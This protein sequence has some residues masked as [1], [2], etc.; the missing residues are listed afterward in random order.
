[1]TALNG[2]PNATTVGV[3]LFNTSAVGMIQGQA[4]A[5]PATR[6]ALRGGIVSNNETVP[7]W[8]GIGVYANVPPI[9][10]NGPR[11]PLGPV[12][13]RA[14][15]LSTLVG[16][17]TFD[18]SYNMI[19]NPAS[20]VPTAGSGQSLNFY[21]LGSRARLAV[22][23]DPA[24]VSLRGGA[25][26]PNVSWDYVNNLLIPYEASA[27]TIT[28]GT[29]VSAT[30]VI[31]LTMAAAVNFSAGDAVVLSSLTGTGGFATLDGTWQA[32]AVS[33]DGLTVTLAGPTGA[34]A[35]TITGGSLALDSNGLLKVVV[36]DV[37]PTGC[38][39]VQNIGGVQTYNY[40]GACAKIQLTGGTVA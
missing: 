6:F 38:M 31:V 2:F 22:A 11:Q 34:G 9:S 13:G 30:G 28:S 16:F 26:N 33:G 25:I 12:I 40:N 29:Y 14:A 36:L 24:L 39:T 5:D 35:S 4:D 7:M 20:P 21:P 18:Q 8:G 19:N 10:T 3:G 17:S 15:G 23:C 32:T 27:F 37:Q 1:M